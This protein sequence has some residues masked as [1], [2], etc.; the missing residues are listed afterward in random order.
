MAKWTYASTTVDYVAN[1]A[2]AGETLEGMDLYGNMDTI[3][4]T[5]DSPLFSGGK[6]LFSG[7]RGDKIVTFSGSNAEAQ[8]DTGLI[9]SPYPTVLTLARPLVD[10][11]SADVAVASQVTLQQVVEQ[12]VG[13]GTVVEVKTAE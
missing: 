8:I 4:T 11:G 9:G 12:L 7:V 10:G 6:Y 13:E 5:F 3:E 1:S 2:T